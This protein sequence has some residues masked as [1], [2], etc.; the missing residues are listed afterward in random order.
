MKFSTNVWRLTLAFVLLCGAAASTQAQFCAT[1]PAPNGRKCASPGAKCNEGAGSGRCTN[2]SDGECECVVK[3][4]PT[5]TPTPTSTPTPTPSP[6]IAH[7]DQPIQAPIY[8][9]IYWDNSWDADNP[10]M[11][12]ATID[13]VT[14]AVIDSSYFAGL[15]EYGV[16]SVSFA[17]SFLPDPS[18]P[19]KAPNSVGF[20][21]PIATSIGGFVQC[22][23]DHGPA[24][25][26]QKNVIYNVIL[27]PSSMES[28]FWSRNFCSGPGSPVAW[29]YH[30]LEDNAPPPFGSGPFSGP[31]IYT[32]VLSNPQ[33]GGNSGL[34]DSLFHEMVEA[35]T[36]PSPIDIS[37]IPPHIN[38]STEN[39]IAD[40]CEG[41]G[42]R[43]FDDSQGATPL[44]SPI[45][46]ASYWSNGQQKCLSFSDGTLPSIGS[47]TASNWGSQTTFAI[48]GS[49]FGS[50]PAQVGLPS[51]ALPYIEVRDN[52]QNWEAG[53]TINADDVR[54]SIPTWSSTQVNNVAFV[55]PAGKMINDL[56][57]EPLTVWLC[58]PG[59]L[60]CASFATTS[61][62]GPYNP[63]LRVL[64]TVLGDFSGSDVIS[65]LLSNRQIMQN[66]VGGVCDPCTFLSLQTVPPGTYTLSQNVS[67]LVPIKIL[68]NGCQQVVVSLGEEASCTIADRGPQQSSGGCTKGGKTGTCCEEDPAGKCTLCAVP[69]ARCP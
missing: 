10:A 16:N 43:I 3:A 19:G 23:H 52:S 31:P 4:S 5:P 67:G 11:K 12:V 30:G 41:Q 14:Q 51:A 42:V 15:L 9:N 69:P 56:P 58:N 21:D 66:K 40:L 2:L 28:D 8:A 32:I 55:V 26:R 36:D 65:I 50:I 54:L 6:R 62:P 59:S 63:R 13:A 33:C 68:S 34:F 25:L 22:E 53:N 1:N 60:K 39:E 46:I 37:I 48:S 44:L 20:Y 57:K 35:A 45:S 29:H 17:G 24:I 61:A 27:P 47:A 7:I 64:N 38:I 49:G 18:C